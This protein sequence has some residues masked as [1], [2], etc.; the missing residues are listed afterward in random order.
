MARMAKVQDKNNY[1]VVDLV[2]RGA[3]FRIAFERTNRKLV[4]IDRN[5]KLLGSFY[6]DDGTL[7]MPNGS[8]MQ[9]NLLQ[10]FVNGMNSDSMEGR[11]MRAN[12]K[13]AMHGKADAKLQEAMR[14]HE[15]EMRAI[16][17]LE[18]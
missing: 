7:D 18:I 5:G 16:E 3:E 17:E 6:L 2:A 8:I 14:R 11:T 13:A 10:S 15:R 12:Y 9:R 1:L 4:S